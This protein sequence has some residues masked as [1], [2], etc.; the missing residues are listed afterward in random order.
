MS[1]SSSQEVK[2]EDVTQNLQLINA[3][4]FLVNGGQVVWAGND[5]IVILNK[6]VPAIPAPGATQGLAYVAP[7]GMIRMS[8]ETLKEISQMLV[9]A[10]EFR[11]KEIGHPIET[12]E[13]R[14]ASKK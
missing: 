8:S 12:A 3:P 6:V 1:A 2:S 11:E 13:M 7:I 9:R 10:I 14:Q 5:P 4:E